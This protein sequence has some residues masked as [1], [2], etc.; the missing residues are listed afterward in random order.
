MPYSR[1]ILWSQT[2]DWWRHNTAHKRCMLD[3]QGYM[4]ARACTRP[5]PGYARAH[6]H[7]HK[8]ISNT[9]CSSTATMIRESASLLRYTYIVSYSFMFALHQFYRHPNES[10]AETFVLITWLFISFHY[11]LVFHLRSSSRAVTAFLVCSN[12]ASLVF[13]IMEVIVTVSAFGSLFT[14]CDYT[15]FT[16][17][18]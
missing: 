13:A 1:K 6:T 14:W 3:K 16:R 9:Y 18:E 5:H 8:P 4:H 12:V 10:C 2:C 17:P 7:T 15:T 11:V